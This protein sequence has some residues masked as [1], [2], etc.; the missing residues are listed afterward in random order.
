MS[1]IRPAGYQV[2]ITPLVARNE[3]GT[4][5]DVTMDIDINDYIKKNGINS[6]Q[7]EVDNGDYDFGIFVF[8]SVTITCIN[9]DGKFSDKSD[10]R[11][12]FKFSRDKT[13]VTINFFDGES[14]TAIT[15]FKGIIDDRAT[16]VNFKSNEVKMI[17]LSEDSIINRVKVAGGIIASG[18]LVSTAIK[19]IL[20]VPEITSVLNYDAANINV[21]DDY[22]IDDVS[23]LSNQT[24]KE[25]LD[26][27][28][29]VSNSVL[30]IE[31]FSDIV[32]RSRE[33]NLDRGVFRFYGENDIFGR[34][35]I[36][37]I[38]NYNTGLHRAFNTIKV[39]NESET[40]LGYIEEFGDNAKDFQYDFI[41]DSAK[42]ATIA[43]NLLDYWKAPRI[44]MEIIAKTK[45]VKDLWFFD[46]VTVDYQ[47][48]VKP[49]S[50]QRLPFYG[51]ARYGTAVY[52]RTFGNIKISKDIAFKVIGKTEDP[53]KFTTIIKLRQV[54]DSIENGYLSDTGTFYGSARYGDKAYQYDPTRV[55]PNTISVYGAGKYGTM[56][57]RN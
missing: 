56:F 57:Y 44:E 19:A 36:I 34:Q 21:L 32:V 39:G 10:S 4:T 26:S 46:L 17:V 40:N 48:R 13:K 11:S 49:A 5:V 6:I 2:L 38:N 27:L 20:N 25:A 35:N 53:L 42:Q 28:L 18:A 54:G 50:G 16:R 24:A 55:N 31:N 37:Q 51:S 30:I 15:S 29:S 45:D 43:A 22:V 8:N 14:N 41:T 7:R 33:V 1:R 47:L 23:T 9:V 3:Y 52:P 12:M